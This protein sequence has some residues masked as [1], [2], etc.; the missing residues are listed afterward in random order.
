MTGR[1]TF[2]EPGPGEGE[3]IRVAVVDSGIAAR[4]PHVGQV[5]AGV[6]LVG[7]DPH[8]TADR[9]GHGTAVAAAIR[10]KAPA[11]T[12][13]PVRV[14][15]RSLATSARTLCEAIRWAAGEGIHILN[16]SLGTSSAAHRP[17]FEA[18]LG[19]AA[20]QGLLVVSAR[21]EAGNWWYPGSLPGVVGV[22][23]DASC[24]RMSVGLVDDALGRGLAASPWPRP[25]PGVVAERN[26]SGVSF[27]VANAAGLLARVLAREPGLQTADAV[28]G[29]VAA[30]VPGPSDPLILPNAGDGPRG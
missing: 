12:L 22:V 4:H 3:G 5:A 29:W 11:C 13:V 16:L 9:L 21:G 14:L 17:A 20:G 6:S 25:I 10:E 2:T 23:A 7:D 1:L 28:L 8:D 18:A 26:L 24:P 19:V 15:D 30:A 27:A